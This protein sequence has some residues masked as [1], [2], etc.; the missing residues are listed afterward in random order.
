[1]FHFFFFL[2]T[3]VFFLLFVFLSDVLVEDRLPRGHEAALLAGERLLVPLLVDV[4]HVALQAVPDGRPVG[5][6]LALEL[7][8]LVVG[9]LHVEVQPGLEHSGVVALVAFELL[10]PADEL[11]VSDLAG[12][13]LRLYQS[14]RVN[15]CHFVFFFLF[16]FF[17]FYPF[18]AK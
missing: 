15:E 12:F 18:F 14:R 10:L 7:L 2:P 5:A 9:D 6:E 1:M 16:L 11:R 4:A 17:F 13:Y 3:R 8:H